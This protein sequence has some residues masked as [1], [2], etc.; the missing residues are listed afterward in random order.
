M[1]SKKLYFQKDT[2]FSIYGLGATGKSVVKT[3]LKY[4]IKNFKCWDDNKER[5][6]SFG[7][8]NNKKMEYYFSQNLDKSDFIITSPGVDIKK[9]KFK[10]KLQK[11]KKK[12]IT[13]IDLFYILNKN[14]KTIVVTGTNGKST[15][16]RIIEHVLK[17][18]KMN[19]I[20]G[21]NLGK[22]VLNLNFK[23]NTYI[24]IEASSFQLAYS[25]FVHPKFAI[26]LN[27][28]KDHLD[29]HGNFR[30]YLNSKFKIF[31][32]QSF[33]DQALLTNSLLIKKFKKEKFK[34]K[35]KL[36]NTK[37]YLNIKNKITNSYIKTK[38]DNSNMSFIFELSKIFK[39]EKKSLIKSLNSFKGL[40]HRQEVFYRK[41][42]IVF[43][44]DSKATSFAATKFA[45]S[46]KKNIIW[47][48][49]GL[50][51]IGDK[52]KLGGLK[53]NILKVYIVG[54]YSNFF[55]RQLPRKIEIKTYKKID[56][57]IISIL[58]D[59]KKISKDKK[60]TVL[61]SPSS[62]SYD[63]YKNFEERGCDFKKKVKLYA[64][65]YI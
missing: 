16:C 39:I 52:I 20:A 58:K 4:K 29:W 28:E 35:L 37:N 34:S 31:A 56:K 6:L 51:K 13:D 8:K 57:V 25:K 22:P 32:N 12:I 61:F 59:I 11:N 42:N 15:I 50:P 7:L 45:L 62:A 19:A 2:N 47:I 10:K 65:E 30:N 27:V 3:L 41:K 5:R 55:K 43:I 54:N 26:V 1:N 23:K 64:K 40:P 53:K 33:R 14:L 49:G 48:T 17:R 46:N 44:N 24:I 63:Q 36:V 60:I 38:V 18:N 9:T 21:G